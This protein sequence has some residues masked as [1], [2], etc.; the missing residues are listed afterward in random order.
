MSGQAGDA[1]YLYGEKDRLEKEN[2]ELKNQI[3][4]HL[5]TIESLNRL[6]EKVK[7]DLEKGK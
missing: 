4:G 3:R 5:K 7:D 2:A 6:I 1:R